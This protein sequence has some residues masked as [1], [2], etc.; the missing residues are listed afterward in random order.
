VFASQSAI[1][2]PVHLHEAKFYFPPRRTSTLQIVD[3]CLYST[4]DE[5]E[6]K[7][8]GTLRTKNI[9]C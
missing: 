3:P 7:A 1:A 4:K 5:I 9:R 2:G 8:F 6:R